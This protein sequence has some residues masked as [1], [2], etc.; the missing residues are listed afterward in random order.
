MLTDQVT[1]S[2]SFITHPCRILVPLKLS[3]VRQFLGHRHE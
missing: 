1:E 2:I 3:Q